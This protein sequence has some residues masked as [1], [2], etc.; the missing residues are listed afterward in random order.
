M[1]HHNHRFLLLELLVGTVLLF[2]PLPSAPDGGCDGMTGVRQDGA[3]VLFLA[4][5]LD[6]KSELRNDVAARS[7]R[8]DVGT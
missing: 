6:E 2:V 7:S 3:M 4:G 5:M 8:R 1:P